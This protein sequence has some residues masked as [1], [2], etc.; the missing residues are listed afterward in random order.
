M[1]KA[2]TL[3]ERARGQTSP[4]PLVGAV[5][6][7]RGKIVGEGFHQRCGL[8]H[9]EAQ[10]LMQAKDAAKNGVLYLNLE[11]CCF[12]SKTPSCVD[13]VIKAG[14]KRVV[15][16]CLDPNPKV[17]GRSVRKM[18]ENKIDVSLGI[19]G[20]E[21]VNLNEIFFKNMKTNLPFVAAKVA[22]SLDGKIATAFGESKWITGEPARIYSHKLRDNYDAVLVGAGTLKKDN[23]RLKGHKKNP[24][25]II[26]SNSFSLDKKNYLFKNQAKKTI[27]FTSFQNRK[28]KKKLPPEVKVLFLRRKKNG[29]SLRQMLEKIYGLGITS[30]F[31]EGGSYTLGK[32][33]QER[34]VDKVYFFLAPK[35]IGGQKALTS[36]G[37]EGAGRLS[38]SLEVKN[39]EIEKIGKDLLIQGYPKNPPT[40]LTPRGC[41]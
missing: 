10:A 19:C 9:A 41:K 32:F 40:P 27:V 38:Q 1:R 33:F 37:A 35:I 21:A 39:I 11:P 18:R 30:F 6:V 13:A 26:I 24:Y 2:L 34:L 3:A 12:E 16:G 31:V 8:P 15:V 28:N 5:V 20:E 7:Q 29:L 22:Q 14:L 23:P 36:V 4:N 25:K 17:N